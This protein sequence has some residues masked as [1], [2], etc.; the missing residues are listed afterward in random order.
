MVLHQHTEKDFCSN[1][2][3]LLNWIILASQRIPDIMKWLLLLGQLQESFI[4]HAWWFFKL[5][6]DVWF[7]FL[8]KAVFYIL[9]FFLGTS[10]KLD[11][12][13]GLSFCTRVTG[14]AWG[15][16]QCRAQPAQPPATSRDIFHSTRLLQALPRLT[17]NVCQDGAAH[18]GSSASIYPSSFRN[19]SP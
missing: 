1:F 9:S 8:N 4:L 5:K 3:V 15:K 11:L 12:E 18:L 10:L 14:V 17:L 6:W 13:G 7:A 19:G 2:G 16:G